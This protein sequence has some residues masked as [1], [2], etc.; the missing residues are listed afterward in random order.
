[1]GDAYSSFGLT[2]VLYVTTF[3]CLGANAR[4]RLRNTNVLVAF[5]V[6]PEVC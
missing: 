4:L 5:E 3:V 2:N 6:I 1:M